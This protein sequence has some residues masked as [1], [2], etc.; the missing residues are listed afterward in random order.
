MGYEQEVQR[1]ATGLGIDL[2]E[3]ALETYAEGAGGLAEQFDI[4]ETTV[5]EAT[6]VSE[7]RPGADEYNA[8]RYR[9][10]AGGGEGPLS[11]LDVA[12]KD[13]IAV[14]GVPMHCGS[15]AV[16]FRPEYHAT[17]VSRLLEDGATL[18]GTTN[19]D[20]F[21]YFTTGETCAFGPTENPRV[22]GAVPGGSSSGSGAAVAAGEVDAALGSDT[23]GSVRIP[24]SFCGVVGLKPTHRSVPRFGFADLAPS[25]DCIGP[26][27][28]DVETAARTYDAVAG[29]DVRDPS[30]FASRPPTDVASG[31]GEAVDGLRVGLVTQALEDAD[32]GVASTVETA[33]E[34]LGSAG[35]DVTRVAVPGYRTATVATLSVAGCEF[36][37]LCRTDGQILGDGTGYSEPWRAAISEAVGSRELGEN[38]RQ[39]LLTAGA[40]VEGRLDRYVAARNFV[41][42]FTGTVGE[43]TAEYDA[44]LTPTTPM[45]APAFGAVETPEEFAHTVANTAPINL[46]GH[47]A[48]SVPGGN[49]DGAPVGVQFVGAPHEERTLVALGSALEA[50]H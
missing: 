7:A 36:A 11:G 27:S 2:D 41:T 8:F 24:A 10:H 25:L 34:H 35:V 40:L 6:P 32:S 29:P 26:L 20:E 16:E 42:E 13:N 31:V 3:G 5:P 47:P 9:C 37:A 46:T 21:A 4:L 44:L 33:G 15:A 17:V 45:T 18:V 28:G 12:V 50:S 1:V 30:T 23:G 48:L 49:V 39:Q 14:A 38:V 22:E 43:L 19:M